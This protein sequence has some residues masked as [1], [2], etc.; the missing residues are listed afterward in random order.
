MGL[1]GLCVG[2]NE[3]ASF[4]VAVLETIRLILLIGQR[5]CVAWRE[6]WQVTAGASASVSP[7]CDHRSRVSFPL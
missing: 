1:D 4:L 2:Y 6:C 7:R 3:Y 5:Q